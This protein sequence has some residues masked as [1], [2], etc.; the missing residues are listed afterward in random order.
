MYP[1]GNS[2]VLPHCVKHGVV[3]ESCFLVQKNPELTNVLHS[4][5]V[6]GQN[7]AMHTSPAARNFSVTQLVTVTLK[8]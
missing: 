6:I 2:L 1:V 5:P 3:M 7:I 8:I 4:K